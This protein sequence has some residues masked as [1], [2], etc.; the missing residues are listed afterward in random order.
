VP[1]Y[2][3]EVL[4]A[5]ANKLITVWVWHR[6]FPRV[7]ACYCSFWEAMD[8]ARMLREFGHPL[9]WLAEIQRLAHR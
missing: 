3:Q 7:F 5:R 1:T 9:V 6:G 8:T 2:E 4:S